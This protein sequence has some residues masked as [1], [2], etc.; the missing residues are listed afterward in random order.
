M[1][2][3]SS[4]SACYAYF[5]IVII[6]LRLFHHRHQ[7]VSPISSPSSAC[8]AFFIIVISSHNHSLFTR[9]AMISLFWFLFD[10]HWSYLSS[11]IWNINVILKLHSLIW[12]LTISISYF[13]NHPPGYVHLP[14]VST[15][16]G[17]LSQSFLPFLLQYVRKDRNINF[18]VGFWRDK[19]YKNKQYFRWEKL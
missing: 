15:R 16:I 17:L 18:F 10:Y 6:L 7:L 19:S 14:N 2:I 9:I 5:I 12:D 11:T 3:S 1:P 4:S 8:Y 13:E